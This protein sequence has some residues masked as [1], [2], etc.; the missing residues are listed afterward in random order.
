MLKT[1]L[2]KQITEIFRGYFFQSENRKKAFRRRVGC[3]VMLLWFS[4]DCRAGRYVCAV[5]IC[6]LCAVARSGTGVDVLC[7][8]GA[9]CLFFRRI[10]QRV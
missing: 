4:D 6:A 2:K 5:V 8:D 10:W 1:L 9:A 7:H 3:D